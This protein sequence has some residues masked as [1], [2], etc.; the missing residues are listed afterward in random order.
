[1]EFKMMVN[2]NWT[3]VFWCPEKGEFLFI[4]INHKIKLIQ[5]INTFSHSW[6]LSQFWIGN[7]PLSQNYDHDSQLPEM[8]PY[9]KFGLLTI[10]HAIQ[11][12]FLEMVSKKY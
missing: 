3:I 4:L 6:S 9:W 7:D 10:Q 8:P 12:T 2:Q 5:K 11:M 1:M